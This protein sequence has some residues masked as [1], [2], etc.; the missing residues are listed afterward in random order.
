MNSTY[1]TRE[2]VPMKS[3]DVFYLERIEIEVVQSKESNCI[4]DGL[5]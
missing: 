1:S 2:M 5:S 3:L 4:L